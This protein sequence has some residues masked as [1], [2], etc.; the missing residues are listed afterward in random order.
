MWYSSYLCKILK[1]LGKGVV[2]K[3]ILKIH[4]VHLSLNQVSMNS[5]ARL[6]GF[7]SKP[8]HLGSGIPWVGHVSFLG[9]SFPTC[10]MKV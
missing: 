3:Q 4:F 10:S 2:Y 6:P 1:P 5:G 8:Y 9:A 7:E